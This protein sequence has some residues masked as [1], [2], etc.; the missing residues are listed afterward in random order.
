MSMH[1]KVGKKRGHKSSQLKYKFKNVND[2][3]TAASHLP[4]S[5]HDLYHK[6]FSPSSTQESDTPSYS[7][8]E[9]LS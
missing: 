3:T 7:E 2:K 6:I 1:D 9:V 8:A 5:A 4:S